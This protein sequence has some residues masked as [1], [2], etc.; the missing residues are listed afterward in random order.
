MA[1]AIV[2]FLLLSTFPRWH[3]EEDSEGSDREVKA[4]PSRKISLFVLFC[5][6]VAAFMALLSA[7]WQ[8]LSAGATMAMV[9]A[10]AYGS[11]SSRTGSAAMAFGWVAT[12]VMIIGTIALSRLVLVQRQLEALTD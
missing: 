9:R 3:P 4:F 10:F 1:F 6:F 8:H 2:G 12:G 11:V 7:F 5:S